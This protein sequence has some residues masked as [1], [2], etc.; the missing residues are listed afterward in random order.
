MNGQ[1][2]RIRFLQGDVKSLF[3]GDDVKT[4]SLAER[5]NGTMT[6]GNLGVQGKLPTET[7]ELTPG[8]FDCVTANPPYMTADG[9]LKGPNDERAAARHE[10]LCTIGDVASAARR[11]L[12]QAGHLYMVHRPHRLGDI[13]EALT[14]HDLAIKR[15]R[16]VHPFA[17]K[18]A[19]MVLIDAVKGAKS[20][21]HVEKPL[22]IYRE[23]GVYTEELK[24]LYG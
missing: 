19:N 1:S 8:S 4:K 10:V 20:Y 14:E 24:A 9:G 12:K 7:L 21:V 2:E 6:S 16:M 3:S 23:K 22:V 15:M 11:A 13:F 5:D 18:E 17:D